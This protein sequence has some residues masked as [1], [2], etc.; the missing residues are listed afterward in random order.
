M[1][2]AV[3]LREEG[4]VIEHVLVQRPGIFGEAERG[5]R[6][7][8]LGQIDGVRDRMR[9]RQIGMARINVHRRDIDFNFGRDLF[10]IETADA[11]CVEAEASFELDG[12]PVG[13]FADFHCEFLGADG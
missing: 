8:E 13:I 7:V 6:A 9:D 12:N 5:E 10:E 4:V 2:I 1:V 11:V 3:S